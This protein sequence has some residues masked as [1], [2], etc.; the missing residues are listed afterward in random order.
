MV[1]DVFQIVLSRSNVTTRM[2]D[3]K[4]DVGS[5]MDVAVSSFLVLLVLVVMVDDGLRLKSFSHLSGSLSSSAEGWMF[6]S[7][8]APEN[9]IL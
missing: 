5:K 9:S 7:P 6:P 1:A 2:S 4:G 3:F 8:F